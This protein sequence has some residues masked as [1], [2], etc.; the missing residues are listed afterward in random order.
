MHDVNGIPSMRKSETDLCRTVSLT[1]FVFRL[2]GKTVGGNL[3]FFCACVIKVLRREE[4]RN[5]GE[6]K[7]VLASCE[8]LWRTEMQII[9][10]IM[11]RG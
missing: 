2:W 6:A 8:S 3:S 1:P 11:Q 4:K 5:F 9:R 10:L 7:Q